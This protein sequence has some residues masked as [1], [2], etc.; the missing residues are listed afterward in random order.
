MATEPAISATRP[1]PFC[2]GTAFEMAVAEDIG[3]DGLDSGFALQCLTCEA[4]GPPGEGA[5]EARQKW[6]AQPP[7]RLTGVHRSV[8]QSG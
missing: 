5:Y 7:G 2:G 3:P 1:C 6:N 8:E 4:Y